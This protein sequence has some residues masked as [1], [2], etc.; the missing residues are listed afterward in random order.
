MFDGHYSTEILLI[1]RNWSDGVLEY[2]STKVLEYWSVGVLECWINP[3]ML[4]KA[5]LVGWAAPTK[6]RWVYFA[7]AESGGA[8]LIIIILTS[9]E[10][11]FH[12][13]T[14]PLLLHS[15]S[16]LAFTNNE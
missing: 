4:R 6:H 5:I 12:Y 15:Y 16:P 7:K 2:W 9:P 3:I 11:L 10:M 1:A 13:S 14:I 8:Q